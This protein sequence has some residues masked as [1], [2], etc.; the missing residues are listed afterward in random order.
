[1]LVKEANMKRAILYARVSTSRQAELYSLDFQ[2]EQEREYAISLGFKIVAEL[3]DDQS[4]RRLERDG[5]TDACESVV[6]QGCQRK[7]KS[8]LKYDFLLWLRLIP[9]SPWLL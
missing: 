2:L 4:G 7:Y 1:M 3:Q 9:I 6:V 5:L 8:S